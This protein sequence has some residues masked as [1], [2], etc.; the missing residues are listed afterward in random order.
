MHNPH[1]P[2]GWGAQV[3]CCSDSKSYAHA[4]D[5]CKAVIRKVISCNHITAQVPGTAW[6]EADL[7][8]I[9]LGRSCGCD[10]PL[11]C[12][13]FNDEASCLLLI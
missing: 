8:Q 1:V 10:M 9:L 13:S 5:L 11:L 3:V 12:M 6:F 4:L 2:A 7:G